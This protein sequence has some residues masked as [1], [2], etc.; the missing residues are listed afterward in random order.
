MYPH[1]YAG[2]AHVGC[3]YVPKFSNSLSLLE[4]TTEEL[5][6]DP[7]QR[8][9]PI[10]KCG[11]AAQ[12]QGYNYF[13]ISVGY[14]ISSS[15]SIHDYQYVLSNLCNHGIGGYSGGYFVMDV[16]HITNMQLFKDS[17]DIIEP[18]S[19][20]TTNTILLP[21]VFPGE[22]D[23]LVTVPS[24]ADFPNEDD[25]SHSS[26]V[27]SVSTSSVLLASFISLIILYIL[28]IMS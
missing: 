3:F 14:C 28:C 12:Q 15:N 6:D 22:N 8:T 23:V 17:A 1:M 13:A 27:T 4:D 16:Y 26:S 11:R 19:I 9:D 5:M 7:L 25:G 10:R 18:A 2:L 24:K 20:T 21:S